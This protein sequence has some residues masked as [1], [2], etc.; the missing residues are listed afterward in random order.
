LQQQARN[1]GNRIERSAG[2]PKDDQLEGGTESRTSATSLA[3][4]LNASST[5]S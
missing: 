1:T 3:L 2:G 4:K 5:S